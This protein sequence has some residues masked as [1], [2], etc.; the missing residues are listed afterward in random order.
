MPKELASAV[1]EYMFKNQAKY[2]A[3]AKVTGPINVNQIY[4][5]ARQ[6]GGAEP[7]FMTMDD[8]YWVEFARKNYKREDNWRMPSILA[9]KHKPLGLLGEVLGLERVEQN[10]KF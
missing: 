10:S 7:V 6:T 3:A 1:K 5:S 4:H 9:W 8:P 2:S